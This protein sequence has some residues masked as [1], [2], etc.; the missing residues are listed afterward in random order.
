MINKNLDISKIEM[1]LCQRLTS[2]M[3]ISLIYSGMRPIDNPKKDNKDT[4]FMV[5]SVPSRVRDDNA[6]GYT[7]I[8]IDVYVPS[9]AMGRKP[10]VEISSINDKIYS[11]IPI[12][13]DKYTYDLGRFP[14]M[15]LGRDDHQ[16]FVSRITL[17][18]IINKTKL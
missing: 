3:P 13:G 10:N 2:V 11:L 18:C 5:V 4:S 16:Y 1:D 17:D 6:Y 15:D 8:S 7:M 12:Y 9:L 14:V